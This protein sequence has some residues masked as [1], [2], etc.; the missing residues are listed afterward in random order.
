MDQ[1]QCFVKGG[2]VVGLQRVKHPPHLGVD[3]A[4]AS[5]RSRHCRERGDCFDHVPVEFVCKRHRENPPLNLRTLARNRATDKCGTRMPRCPQRVIRA[6][7]FGI[8]AE[9]SPGWS[10]PARESDFRRVLPSRLRPTLSMTLA[11]LLDTTSLIRIDDLTPGPIAL[12]PSPL[13]V[14]LLPR[15]SDRRAR[16]LR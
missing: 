4:P 13:P 10:R 12:A 11:R 1:P 7:R 9:P 6:R 2:C 5:R 8:L 14:I 3:L 16:V 15:R